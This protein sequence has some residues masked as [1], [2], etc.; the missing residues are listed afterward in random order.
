[1]NEIFHNLFVLELANNHWGSLTRGKQIV[2][3]FASVVRNNK[4][5][6]AIKLQFR[7]VENFIHNEFVDKGK[8]QD[9][10]TL[11]KKERYIQKTL[12]TKLSFDEMSELVTYIKKTN[13]IP[14]ATPFDEK[15][16]DWCVQFDLPIIKVSSADINDWILL[17]KIA[18][19]KKPVIISTGGANEKQIDD[20]VKFFDNRKIPLAINHCVSK[21]PSEDSELELNQIDYLKARYP[22]H[23][24]G[25]STHEYHDWE[26]SMFISYA[27]G[28]RTWERHIDIPYPKNHEQK[29]VSKY[30]SLPEQVD[31]WFKA[32]HKANQMCGT[33]S[34]QRRIIDEK[35]STY[36]SALYRGFY[37]N[38]DLK[39]GYTVTLKDVNA[40]VPYLQEINQITSREFMDN[41]FVLNKDLKKG[42]PLTKDDLQ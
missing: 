16:V 2:K 35:E 17:Q 36:L 19:T 37:V 6:A 25:F 28:V 33:S 20:V 29:E 32:F 23:T 9:L 31:V 1:M 27:K 26:S 14:M 42:S 18:S 3:E 4:I 13:C 40:A 38:K 24:I 7:D 11:P 41:E 22:N 30:C 8:N 15:S 34:S 39:K 10:L 5:K 21:Y 12:K